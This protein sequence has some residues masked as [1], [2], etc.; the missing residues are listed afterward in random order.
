VTGWLKE[1][2]G[3]QLDV[4]SQAALAVSVDTVVHAVRTYFGF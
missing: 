1:Q 2:A 3:K 4:Q